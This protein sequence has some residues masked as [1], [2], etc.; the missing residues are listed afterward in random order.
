MGFVG[1]EKSSRKAGSSSRIFWPSGSYRPSAN[2]PKIDGMNAS[3]RR[4]AAVCLVPGLG[5]DP[6]L[7]NALVLPGQSH[8]ASPVSA[9]FTAQAVVAPLANFLRHENAA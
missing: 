8:G 7:A 3:L 2:R 5:F 9:Y 6:A 1:P 4:L